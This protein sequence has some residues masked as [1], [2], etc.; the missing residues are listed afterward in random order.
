MR[1][2]DLRTVGNEGL[3]ADVCVG[4]GPAEPSIAAGLTNSALRPLILE[5]GGGRILGARDRCHRQCRLLLASRANP[6]RSRS[7]GAIGNARLLL[8]S[9]ANPQC[10]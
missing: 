6:R 2:E 9:R 3:F 8:A 1:I 4:S 10:S 5:S 7:V